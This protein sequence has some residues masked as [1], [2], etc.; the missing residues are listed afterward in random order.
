MTRSSRRLPSRDFAPTPKSR[1]TLLGPTP[2]DARL[3]VANHESGHAVLS[4]A[5]N[6]VPRL[7][8]IRPREDTLG[9]SRLRNVAGPAE[10]V[11][12]HLAGFAAEHLVTGHRARELDRQIGLA[13]RAHA[14]PEEWS[15]V[16]S[17]EASFD[18]AL[19]VNELLRIDARYTDDELWREIAHYYLLTH[20]SLAA[21]WGAVQRVVQALL[22]HGELSSDDISKALGDEDVRGTVLQVRT[23][24]EGT[25]SVET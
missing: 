6:E 17:P 5:L 24:F 2:V 25:S 1:L 15:A 7:I 22:L 13:V 8:S 9:R 21:I 11:Q 14:N 12:V 10:L 19:A 23:S 3:L 4:A 16:T 18:G 20:A